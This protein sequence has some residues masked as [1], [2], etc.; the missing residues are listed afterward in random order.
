MKT[1]VLNV[2]EPTVL[3][4]LSE[5]RLFYKMS[6]PVMAK[7]EYSNG[8]S[9]LTKATYIFETPTGE[10]VNEWRFLSPGKLKIIEW[11]QFPEEGGNEGD[12]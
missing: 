8:K 11:Y 4:P 12:R 7:V 6:V 5:D 10:Q 3:P 1:I 9:A 2:F